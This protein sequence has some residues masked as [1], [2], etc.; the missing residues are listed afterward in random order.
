MKVKVFECDKN[1]KISFT[2]RELENLLN[3]IYNNGY[4]DG[5]A[6][7]N[8][9]WTWTYPSYPITTTNLGEKITDTP[10]TITCTNEASNTLNN[11]EAN[12]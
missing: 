4:T 3:E 2:K 6:S 5:K 12:K 9:Y 8:Y 1:G 7:N 10:W 11:I